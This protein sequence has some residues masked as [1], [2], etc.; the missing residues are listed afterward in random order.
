MIEST[1]N[2]IYSFWKRV[3]LVL[4]TCLKSPEDKS[5]STSEILCLNFYRLSSVITDEL[6]KWTSNVKPA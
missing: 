1:I 4:N 6:Y 2:C 5:V 3:G